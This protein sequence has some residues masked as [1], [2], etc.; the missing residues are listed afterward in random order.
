[1]APIGSSISLRLIGFLLAAVVLFNLV[2]ALAIFAPLGRSQ[3]DGA[4]LPLPRQM[5]AIVD[6]LDAAAPEDRPRILT[7]LNSNTLAVS[8]VDGLPAA[9]AGEG[10][11][12]ASAPLLTR[13]LDA[14]DRAFA[15]RDLHVD[16]Q[17]QGFLE[18]LGGGGDGW[19]AVR[20]FVGLADGKWVRIQPVR[21]ALMSGVLWRGLL[22]VG[23]TGVVVIVLLVI[24]VRQT[25]RP[26]EK[27]A[28]GARTFA[29]KLD[30][31]DLDVKGSKELRDL[32]AAFNDMKTRIRSLVQ[33]RTRLV[34][35]IAHD[36]RTYLT[37]LR[38]R[39]EFIED[40]KQR[41]RAEADIEEMSAL[42]GDTL[43]FAKSVERQSELSG[44]TDVTSEFVSF[45][46]ARR[47][48]GDPV[49]GP[50]APPAP[51]KARI[52]PVAL[53][54][55]LS[56]LTD[57]AIRYGGQAELALKAEGGRVIIE[58]ADRGPG[59]AADDLER[60]LAP[61]E[62]LEPSRGREAGGAGLGLAIVKALVD[63]H[64]GD[65]TMNNRP[66]GGLMAQVSMLAAG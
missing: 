32:A 59:I 18:R 55:I 20:I 13:F 10:G 42:I 36:L 11:Q 6:V 41:E 43:L 61:F 52:E 33:E 19:S 25:A 50:D 2:M 9:E 38:M 53:R 16:M 64:G 47:E 12:P 39:A 31:P 46:A 1:M 30:A 29:D 40:P 17:R 24:A 8:I 60:M 15:T 28:S 66:G 54:R 3:G 23:L 44:S 62:R 65:F 37:R 57:N 58:V 63:H 26:I 4:R 45:L 56:N 7:A 48:M 49:S 51:L 22:I 27:L 5:A 35:A 14:Y 21:G 34:A